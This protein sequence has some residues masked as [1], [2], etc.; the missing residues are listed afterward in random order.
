MADNNVS[1]LAEARLRELGGL[2]DDDSLRAGIQASALRG[3]A[4]LLDARQAPV[5]APGELA[6]LAY[7]LAENADRIAE[8]QLLDLS[9]RAE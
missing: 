8:R 9:R 1:R 7:I 6:A 4:A 3:F 2:G 5:C